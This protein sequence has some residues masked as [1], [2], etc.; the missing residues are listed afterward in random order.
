M[1]ISAENRKRYPRDWG[2]ISIYIRF[3]VAQGRCEGCGAEHAKPHP[4]TG[5][6][7]VLTTAHLFDHR[8][9]VSGLWNLA[10]LCQA[11]H[12]WYDAPMRRRNYAARRA[13]R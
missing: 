1:P 13:A 6:L 11:C 7:V 9:E 4:R 12:N 5:S 3:E 8:P 2:A 10:A